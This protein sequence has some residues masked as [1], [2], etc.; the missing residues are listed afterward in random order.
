MAG[1]RAKNSTLEGLELTRDVIFSSPAAERQVCRRDAGLDLASAVLGGRLA[2]VSGPDGPGVVDSDTGEMIE[3]RSAAFAAL[4][5]FAADDS[6]HV[7]GLLDDGHGGTFEASAALWKSSLRLDPNWMETMRRRSRQKAGAAMKRMMDG[8]SKNERLARR[9]N[10]AQRLTL[11]LITLTMP[12][13]T[14]A[15][16]YDETKRLNKALTL[17]KKREAW[18]GSMVGGIKGVEDAL[19]FDGPHVHAHMLM[20]GSFVERAELVEA[21]REC[22][23]AAT[24]ELLGYGLAEDSPVI[25]DIRQV[26]KKP[27]GRPDRIG[28]EDA[29]LEVTK[30]VTKPSDYL[31]PDEQGRTIPRSVLLELCEVR[32]WPRMFELLGRCRE[33][34]PAP[35]AQERADAA[36]A[37]LVSIHRAYLT[38]DPI[39]IPDKVGWELVEAWDFATDGPEELRKSIAHALNE[40]EKVRPKKIRPPTWRDLLDTIGL[41]EWL[42]IMA[43]RFRRGKTYRMNQLLEANPSA[44]LCTFHGKVYGNGPSCM[45]VA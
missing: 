4:L 6:N 22:L 33:V 26:S 3:D 34:K 29:L 17:L 30:Y 18:R 31:K 43:D 16:S 37:A 38:G 9:Y 36:Q 35:G 41:S 25:L 39:I 2:W 10:W 5:A 21:W 28:W 24:R 13:I 19:D 12:H 1:S 32:R 8:L 42:G 11:K 14:G 23:D 15:T 40:R 7:A 44:Y 27:N 20:L 45:V